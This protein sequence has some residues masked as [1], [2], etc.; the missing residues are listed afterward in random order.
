MD[1]QGGL[2]E[3]FKNYCRLYLNTL[4]IPKSPL[5]SFAFLFK[6]AL[7]HLHR[8]YLDLGVGKAYDYSSSHSFLIGSN[9]NVLGNLQTGNSFSTPFFFVRIGYRWAQ[10]NIPWFPSVNMGLRHHYPS[11][12]NVFVVSQT[13][14]VNPIPTSYN[15][16]LLQESWL[17][18]SKADIYKWKRFMPY[19]ALG[20]GASFNRISQ[21]FVNSAT[22]ANQLGGVTNLK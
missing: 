19:V 9:G 2:N 17:L 15:Y 1:C 18:M 22:F 10:D 13:P 4:F 12:V 16:R 14:S 7:S 3:S 8:L 5:C 6:N 11:P 20:L 21:L